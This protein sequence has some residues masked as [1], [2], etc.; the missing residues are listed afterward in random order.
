MLKAAMWIHG[1]AVVPE[2]SPYDIG[3]T[4]YQDRKG[5]G[6][7][8]TV[9][10]PPS[11]I[12]PWHNWYHF[13]IPTPV[14]LDDA[15]PVLVKVFVLYQTSYVSVTDLHV[16]DGATKIRAFGGFKFSGNH[17]GGID[18]SNSWIIGPPVTILYGLGISVGVLFNDPPVTPDAW[19][20]FASAGADFAQP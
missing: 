3:G 13:Q 12:W 18:A 4:Y 7:T 14:I 5:W 6:A 9:H 11:A 10:E 15:R 20:L 2:I 19:I 1:N 17:I 16:Y 8:Y